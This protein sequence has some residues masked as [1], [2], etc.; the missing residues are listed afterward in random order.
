MKLEV[1]PDKWGR[2]KKGDVL[3]GIPSSTANALIK[4]GKVRELK[5]K[6]EKS[7]E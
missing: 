6:K 4:S 1:I 5:P 3:Q 7:N 2:Y